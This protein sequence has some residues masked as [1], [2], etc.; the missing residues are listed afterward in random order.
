M[1]PPDLGVSWIG[2]HPGEAWGVYKKNKVG[3][4][5]LVALSVASFSLLVYKLLEIEKAAG[6]RLANGG[7]LEESQ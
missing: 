5:G 3:S 1:V 4:Q 2:T 7:T 6:E